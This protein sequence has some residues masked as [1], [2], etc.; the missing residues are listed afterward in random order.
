MYLTNSDTSKKMDSDAELYGLSGQTLMERAGRGAADYILSLFKSTDFNCSVFCGS[1][2]NGGDGYVIA[3][4]LMMAGVKVVCVSVGEEIKTS[5]ADFMK[6]EFESISG[7]IIP[8]EELDEISDCEFDAVVDALLGTG[9]NKAVGGDYEKAVNCI[10]NCGGIK[11]GIDIPSGINADTGEVMGCAVKCNHTI[12]FNMP[13]IA[14]FLEKSYRLC[15]KIKVVDIGIPEFVKRSYT[16]NYE[17]IDSGLLDKHILP[18][19]V[20]GYK[21][22]FGSGLIVGGSADFSGSVALASKAA[23]RSGIGI[24]TCLVPD[25]CNVNTYA[26][27]I[28]RKMYSGVG[29]TFSPESVFE[30]LKVEEKS[31][32]S[33]IGVG[34]GHDRDAEDF[35]IEYI[36][37]AKNP[38]VIDADGI[39]I[40]SRNIDILRELKQEIILTPHDMEL[41]RLCNVSIGE[42]RERKIELGMTLASEY[43]VNAVLKGHRTVVCTPDGRVLINTGGNP[44]MAKGGSGDVLA[45]VILSFLCQ[46]IE[47]SAAAACGVWVCSE[48]GDM[49]AR[50][51]GEYGMLPSDTIERIPLVL[52][53]YNNREW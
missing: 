53:K 49:C 39:N 47:A 51:I 28:V 35:F 43:A 11:F 36:K 21:Y 20:D 29:G 31:F 45:G 46:G 4:R 52:K 40:L 15:G 1:G 16:F 33:L 13:K 3:R 30:A 50:E 19:R 22:T 32:A 37:A 25:K 48:A 24:L 44:G 38:I 42:A 8:L 18:K 6:K 23:L 17:T 34:M 2:N 41:A 5:D 10:N 7:T 27:A 9:I 12:T 26:E 14:L